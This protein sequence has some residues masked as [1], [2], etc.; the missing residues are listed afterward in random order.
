MRGLSP[1]LGFALAALSLLA[2]SPLA[3]DPLRI[4][5][6]EALAAQ[7]GPY[8]TRIGQVRVAP[9]PDGTIV[10]ILRSG[11]IDL[12]DP[13]PDPAFGTAIV[14]VL[15]AQMLIRECPVFSSPQ[16]EARLEEL[17]DLAIPRY[18][19]L[20]DA[21]PETVRQSY[22]AAL[23]GMNLPVLCDHYVAARLQDWTS[24]EMETRLR[25]SM[26]ADRYPAYAC[27]RIVYEQP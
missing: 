9:L 13:G 18:A 23:D 26:A 7:A 5:D 21:S 17:R 11:D 25:L 24:P 1:L 15:Q 6:L 16:T 22:D 2:A 14:D 27:T 10:S 20:V 3:A 8:E 4:L 19:T 12:C